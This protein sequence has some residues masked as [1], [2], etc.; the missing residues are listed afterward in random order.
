ME[1]LTNKNPGNKYGETPFHYAAKNGRLAI[2]QL[3]LD[4][5]SDKNPAT[6]SLRITPLH[7]AAQHGHVAICKIIME[8]IV[9]KNPGT[10]GS[11]PLTPLSV[12]T[13]HGHLEVCRLFHAEGIH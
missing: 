7:Y 5:L 11:Q 12:A 1:N 9:D 4:T 10:K 13:F 8:N 6:K 3:M 2:C